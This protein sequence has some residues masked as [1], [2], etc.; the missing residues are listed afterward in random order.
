MDEETRSTV[1]PESV[2]EFWFLREFISTDKHR[3]E[4]GLDFFLFGFDRI[5]IDTVFSIIRPEFYDICLICYDIHKFE[6]I[7]YAF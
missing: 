3:T 6:L 5:H 7:E 2:I 4:K 1:I